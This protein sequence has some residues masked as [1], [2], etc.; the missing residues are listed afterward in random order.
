MNNQI[1]KVIR[2]CLVLATSST[3]LLLGATVAFGAEDIIESARIS[4]QKDIDT[5]CKDVTR[6]EGRILQCLSAHQDKIS[7]RCTYAVDDAALQLERVGRAIKYVA[8]ECK[9]DLLKHCGD[10]PVGDGRI[11]QCLKKNDATLSSDCK[12]SLK[13]TQMEIK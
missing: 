3:A 6:G 11:A 2:K 1:L 12:Q 4:C 8:D 13:D 9:A 7:G 5:Y 10:I